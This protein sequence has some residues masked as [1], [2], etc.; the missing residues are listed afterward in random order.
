[1]A[2]PRTTGPNRTR[3]L[4]LIGLVAGFVIAAIIGAL[5]P[6]AAG[7]S[8]TDIG[9]INDRLSAIEQKLT[10]PTP[11]PASSSSPSL[12][13]QTIA[14][15]NKDPKSHVDQTVT[16]TGKVNSAHQGVGFILV[17]NDGSF[18]WIHT[19]DKI[20]S[21]KATVHGKI[22]SLTDQLAQWKNESGWAADDSSLTAKLRDEKIFLEADSVS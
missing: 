20:P 3:N 8:D 18:L 4:F 17:D 13:D 22:Q 1:M 21:A 11:A 7:V 14:G 6:R 2:V 5:R 9:K 10:T 15:L 16:V 19:H 12:T